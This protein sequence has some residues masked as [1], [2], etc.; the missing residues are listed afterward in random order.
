MSTKPTLTHL[1]LTYIIISGYYYKETFVF[2]VSL[3]QESSF[4]NREVR[5]IQKKE[6]S[7]ETDRFFLEIA[8][9][10]AEQGEA[11]GCYPV[12]AL[13]VS[14]D[15]QVLSQGHNHVIS[16]GDFTSHAEIEAIRLAGRSLM[17]EP[18]AGTC[19][20]FT[21]MEPCLMCLGALFMADI[22]RVVWLIDDDGYGAVRRLQSNSLISES[23]ARITFTKFSERDLERRI[24]EMLAAWRKPQGYLNSRWLQDNEISF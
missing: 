2:Y 3:T 23:F 14:S 11:E 8:M 24:R 16:L 10:E 19:T 15:G 4:Y 13:V 22:T 20:L 12:G 17:T 1:W 9:K 18:Y 6:S 7:L 21:T 5:Q